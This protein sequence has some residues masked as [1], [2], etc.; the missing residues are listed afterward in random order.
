MLRADV[1]SI[2]N[3]LSRLDVS[4]GRRGR[5]Q[6]PIHRGDNHQAFSYDD[7]RGHWFCFRCGVGGDAIELVKRVLDTDFKGA[8][9]WLGLEPGRPPQPDPATVRRQ[10]A[11][12]GLAAWSKRI[13]R[14]LRFE[15]YV[16]EKVITRAL[17]RLRQNADDAYGWNWLGWA[18]TGHSALE[19]QLDMIGGKEEQRL[20]VYKHWR[21]VA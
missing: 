2:S 16:R 14:D 4:P 6:C 3:I 8:L 9:R 18:L 17:Q 11:R 20:E 10:R 12:A 1:P 15:F 13:G 19:Y 7:H 5:T 21:M